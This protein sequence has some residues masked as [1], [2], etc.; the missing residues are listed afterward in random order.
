[1]LGS[2]EV[3]ATGAGRQFFCWA[4]SGLEVAQQK[5]RTTR[6]RGNLDLIGFVFNA[7]NFVLG[8][9]AWD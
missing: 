4:L 6:R 3:A 8:A 5:T 7:L 1:M 2:D 9:L